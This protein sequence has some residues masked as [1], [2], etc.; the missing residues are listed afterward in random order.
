LSTIAYVRGSQ[1]INEQLNRTSIVHQFY[2]ETGLGHEYWGTS[3]GTFPPGGPNVYWLNIITKAKNFMLD[4]MP[5]LPA[6]VSPVTLTSFTGNK[7][8]EKI[9]LYWTTT[10]ETNLKSMI[11]ERS[12]DGLNFTSLI[13]MQPRG[14]SGNG[15]S[16]STTD[17]F[18]YSGNSFYRLK[19][20]DLDGSFAYSGILSFQTKS[21]DLIV[22]QLYPNPV[23]DRLYMQLQSAKDRQVN[24]SIFDI[25]GKPLQADVLRLK[26][27]MNNTDISFQKLEGGIYI[28]RFKN[29][30][31]GNLLTVKIVK[32]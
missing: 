10:M 28:I 20:I 4:R 21:Q 32:Q 14:T 8:D 15:A 6:C 16:Y 2:Y 23:R 13:S 27:G 7:A 11:V 18:P 19:L 29:E 24:V 3:N 9:Y 26:K 17:A 5:E 25:T 1:Q 31:E 12:D 22:T 30:L